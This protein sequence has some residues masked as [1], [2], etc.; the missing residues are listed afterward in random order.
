MNLQKEQF[1]WR[2]LISFPYMLWQNASLGLNI[3]F[4]MFNLLGEHRPKV[5]PILQTTHTPTT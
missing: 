1:S 3:C 2:N 5:T 4:L